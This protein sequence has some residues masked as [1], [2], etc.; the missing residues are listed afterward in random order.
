MGERFVHTKESFMAQVKKDMAKKELA[1]REAVY[2]AKRDYF[3]DPAKALIIDR[4]RD[5]SSS[6]YKKT[7]ANIKLGVN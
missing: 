4:V 3:C 7:K 2:K 6:T 5:Q 1:K